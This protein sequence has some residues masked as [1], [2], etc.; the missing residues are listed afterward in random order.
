M[1]QCR[2]THYYN[3]SV[4]R[5]KVCELETIKPG[6][7]TV[8]IEVSNNGP[9]HFR[10]YYLSKVKITSRK[11]IH[12]RNDIYWAG[13]GDTDIVHKDYIQ[14]D[15]G[16]AVPAHVGDT[17]ANRQFLANKRDGYIYLVR[18]LYDNKPFIYNCV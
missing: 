7:E 2:Y 13:N 12:I 3:M 16:E 15:N 17:R 9:D 5:R 18:N 10:V 11:G 1:R 6:F 8:A 4:I 14:M